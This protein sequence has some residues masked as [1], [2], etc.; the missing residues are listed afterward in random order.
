MLELR[1]FKAL[2]DYCLIS[3]AT[4]IGLENEKA[5]GIGYPHDSGLVQ[6]LLK[7]F[8]LSLEGLRPKNLVGPGDFVEGVSDMRKGWNQVSVVVAEVEEGR[9]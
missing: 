1:I 3:N 5:L 9:E 7:F 2:L 4:A 6:L 8:K